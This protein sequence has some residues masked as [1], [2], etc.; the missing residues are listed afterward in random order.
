MA[1]RDFKVTLAQKDL[2]VTQEVQSLGLQ[3]PWVCRATRVQWVILALRVK[4]VLK[5][6]RALVGMVLKMLT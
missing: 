3:A 6:C 1:T 2:L 5:D 4:L